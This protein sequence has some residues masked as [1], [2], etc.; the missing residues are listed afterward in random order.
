MS[1]REK[2][3]WEMSWLEGDVEGAVENTLASRIIAGRLVTS[4]LVNWAEIV[5]V[6]HSGRPGACNTAEQGL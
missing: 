1:Y 5:P 6:V 2:G 3:D 4:H